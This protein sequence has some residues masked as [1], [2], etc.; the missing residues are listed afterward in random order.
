MRRLTKYLYNSSQTWLQQ[1]AQDRIMGSLYPSFTVIYIKVVYYESTLI[2]MKIHQNI[3]EILSKIGLKK[4]GQMITKIDQ[5]FDPACLIYLF[6]TNY[7]LSEMDQKQIISF[8]QSL[9]FVVIIE[10]T[11]LYFEPFK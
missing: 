7:S 10:N 5:S 6:Q 4:R 9:A 2:V 11:Q 3:Y 8:R 1:T